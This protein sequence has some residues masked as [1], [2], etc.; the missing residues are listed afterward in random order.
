VNRRRM[1]AFALAVPVALSLLVAGGQAGVAASGENVEY[2][3]LIEA[4]AAKQAAVA[5]VTAAGGT[6]IRENAAVGALVVAAPAS[7]F[8]QLVSASPAVYGAAHAK[9]IGRVPGAG[10]VAPPRDEVESEHSATPGAARPS[11]TTSVGMDPLDDR[12]WGLQ[13]VRSHLSREV[14]PGDR[15]V[16]VG[17]L[18]S[19]VDLTHPDIAPNYDTA[20]SRNFTIDI[21]FDETGAVVDGPCE[22]RG[23]VDPPGW[24]DNGH[25][26]HVAGIVAAAANGF[27]VSGVA[28]N[29][30]IVSI[31][32][33]QDSGYVFLQ[34]VLDALAYGADAGLDVINMSFYIDPWLYNCTSNPA[35]SPEDQIEQQTTIAAVNRALGYAHQKGV[36]LVNSLGNEHNDHGNPRDDLTSPDYPAGAAYPRDIDNATCLS[37]PAEGDHVIAV[38]ALGP[39]SVKADYSNYGVEQTTLSAPGGYF[40]DGLGTP[41]YRTNE[42]LILSTY[43]RNALLARGW[44]DAEGNITPAGTAAAVLRYCDATTCGYYRYIQGTSM[45]A[46]H[47]SGVAA[48]VVSRFGRRDASG[49]TL[50]PGRVENVL[51]ETAFD[52]PCPV[53]PLFSYADVGRPPEYDALCEGTV[54]FN[55]F[56]GHG[57]VDAY[58]AVTRRV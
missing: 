15:R 52:R 42:N 22:F 4:G 44:I 56:Y 10:G 14:Q 3:V 47:V 55:G 30:T 51:T 8:I 37:L 32:G 24:D 21:P 2:T 33:G 53:P 43:P 35:D 16:L 11:S 58:A 54:E 36:T 6:V 50:S 25:G 5:A 9:P 41:W 38:S 23:C 45:A 46:P 28:P 34:P 29:V 49:L 13:M 17:I 18:D 12:L 7:G 31:R 57:V 20:R 1:S 19:G 27:G 39:S 26:T 48:L 40:R